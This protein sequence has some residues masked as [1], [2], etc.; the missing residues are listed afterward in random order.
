MAQLPE[1]I[2]VKRKSA[3]SAF[4][5]HVD[6]AI[7]GGGIIGC[8]TAYYLAKRGLDVAVFEKSH[9][10]AQEQSGKNWGFVRQ[11]G[12]DPEEL[13]LM[14]RSN[15]LWQGLEKELRADLGWQQ[16]GI[17]GMTD[18][19]SGMPAYE[20]W[21]DAAKPYDVETRIL[22]GDAV[23]DLL[24]GMTRDWVGGIYVPSDGNADPEKV[25][26]A[27]ADATLRKKGRVL[28]NCAVLGV[29]TKAGAVC[30]ISTEQGFVTAKTVVVAA[31]AWTSR[32]L[33]WLNIDLPQMRVRGTVGRT[34]PTSRVSDIAAWTPHLGFVQRKDGCFT[35]S[36]L[37][38]SDFDLSL[39]AI[40]YAKYYLPTFMKHRDMVQLQFG[41]PFLLDLIGRIP[42]SDAMRDPLRRARIAD[43]RPNKRK[44][45]NTLDALRGLFDVTHDIQLKKAWGGHI[46]M[47]PDMLPVI[48]GDVGVSGLIVVTGL[49]GHGF[50]MGPGVGSVV[51]EIAAG[52]TP[53]VDLR[54]FRLS[55][56][57]EGDWDEPYNLI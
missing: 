25:T 53:S 54:P 16:G 12:R 6:V 30:G 40:N 34:M 50:G 31:G 10:V 26:Q 1:K 28:T 46:E 7:I 52:D 22:S 38:V 33:S 43:P 42:G 35:F 3:R 14:I 23:R 24:P 15:R 11:L 49:S 47:T 36:G 2:P 37:D 17:L 8:S 57:A 48:D 44:L 51:A 18:D 32:V 56:F 27:F 41:H 9:G 21:R 19:E 20:Q 5:D 45:K 55:R 4:P 39:D 13:P 29:E